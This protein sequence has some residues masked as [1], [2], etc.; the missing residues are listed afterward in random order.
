[1]HNKKTTPRTVESLHDSYNNDFKD[2]E[3]IKNKSVFFAT[4]WLMILGKRCMQLQ[5]ACVHIVWLENRFILIFYFFSN[6]FSILL[7]K[8]HTSFKSFVTLYGACCSV[9][10][11]KLV[12]SI[13]KTDKN[14]A[15]KN[16]MMNHKKEISDKVNQMFE[17]IEYDFYQFNNVKHIDGTFVQYVGQIDAYNDPSIYT[18]FNPQNASLISC[19]VVGFANYSYNCKYKYNISGN[20]DTNTYWQI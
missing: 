4:Q 20:Y 9:T 11:E 8:T 1:M 7:Y 3:K 15:D 17:D 18:Q 19:I 16:D 13:N 10:E 12:D 5:W 2:D 6:S 14:A